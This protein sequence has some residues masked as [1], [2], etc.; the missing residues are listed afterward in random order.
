MHK[1]QGAKYLP[2]SHAI[3]PPT[4]PFC[5]RHRSA[6]PSAPGPHPTALPATYYI[7]LLGA[8]SM[9]SVHMR[10]EPGCRSSFF[11]ED[12]RL[13]RVCIDQV[14]AWMMVYSRTDARQDLALNQATTADNRSLTWRRCALASRRSSAGR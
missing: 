3:M 9:S 2:V 1:H 7:T 5:L 8:P 12:A 6:I 11:A 10:E 4:T 13:C 14:H